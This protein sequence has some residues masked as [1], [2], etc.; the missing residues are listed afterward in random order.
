MINSKNTTFV[1]Q[2]K[3]GVTEASKHSLDTDSKKEQ[4]TNLPL[5]KA[6][7]RTEKDGPID[8]QSMESDD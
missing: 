3:L 7:T 5:R 1:N 2:K 8:S 6:N 4:M